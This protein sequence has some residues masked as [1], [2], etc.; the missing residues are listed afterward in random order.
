MLALQTCGAP[1]GPVERALRWLH[2]VQRADGGWPPH[3]AVEES[4]W[5]SAVV[6]LVDPATLGREAHRRGIAWMLAQSGR[7]G[8]WLSRLG[9]FV[10]GNR[11]SAERRL[12]GWPWYPGT[13]AWVTPTALT[14]LALRK[15]L[16]GGEAAYLH[17]RLEMGAA[18]LV[19]HACSDGGWNYGAERVLGYDAES[20][21][22]TTG[23][24]LLALH[25]SDSQ[26]IPKACRLARALLPACQNSEAGSWLRL[27]LLAHG[28]F[29]GDLAPAK[30]PQRTVLQT[31][32]AL[33]ADAAQQGRNVFLE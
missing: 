13:T 20:Y 21:P 27:G 33:L 29:P 24:A 15:A 5:V 23:V 31:A 4:T 19:A 18:F 8:G 25:G 11:P 30:W 10:L 9:L 28:Q 17:A 1:A 22:E 3:P 6:A 2:A 14:M 16:C 26:Q 7:E 32:L 12:L